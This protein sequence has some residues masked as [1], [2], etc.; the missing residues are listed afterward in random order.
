MV[1]VARERAATFKA[2]FESEPDVRKA[3]LSGSLRR[4]T[5]LDPV[6]DVDMVIEYDLVDHPDWGQPG[7][8]AGEAVEH[9]RTRCKALLGDPDGTFAELVRRAD[10]RNRAAKC[11]V[12]D[13]DDPEAFT[14]DV[15]PV[16]RQSADALHIPDVEASCWITANPEYLIEC[17]QRRHENWGHYR[18]MVRVLKAWRLSVTGTVKI[19]SLVMEV[20]AW[21]YLP[22][23]STRADALAT[24]FEAAATQV[25]LPIED[26]AGLCGPIQPDLDV[27]ALRTALEEA[28]DIAA[29]A[30][31][32]ARRGDTDE[33][34]VLWGRVLGPEFPAPALKSRTT[35]TA[36]AALSTL[37]MI[38]RPQG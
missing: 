36:S 16:I 24:F 4:S 8:S 17:A 9:A 6:H 37:S 30:Q 20:L 14:V 18:H 32:A 3:W 7:P 19:R 10:G 23:G 1:K 21:E 38:N 26:P 12:D 35:S 2:A 5:Q 28:A 25:N 34:L 33:A 29:S 11:F 27:G 22:D 31:V 15:M 13:P